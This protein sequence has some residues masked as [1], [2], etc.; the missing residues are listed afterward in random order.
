MVSQPLGI[1]L[2]LSILKILGENKSAFV[3]FI[4]KIYLGGLIKNFGAFLEKKL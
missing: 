3:K 1:V 2:K 4:K